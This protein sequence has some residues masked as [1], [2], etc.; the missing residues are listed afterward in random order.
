LLFAELEGSES[1]VLWG[2][3]ILL[4]EARSCLGFW[5]GEFDWCPFA[6]KNSDSPEVLV[7]VRV[8][9]TAIDIETAREARDGG[10]KRKR[11]YGK[12]VEIV[13]KKGNRGTE[14]HPPPIFF[15]FFFFFG[16]AYDAT[17]LTG[18]ACDIS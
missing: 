15:F 18:L 14:S 4:G 8:P 2:G 17:Q 10:C 1:W 11:S 12:R 9:G 5:R 6:P 7:F 16:G 3:L 13:G